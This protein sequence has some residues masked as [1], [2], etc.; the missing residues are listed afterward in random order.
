MKRITLNINEL[1]K[2]KT[3]LE[4][5]LSAWNLLLNR[6]VA[7]SCDEYWGFISD[8]QE[9]VEESLERI[10][11]ILQLVK[12]QSGVKNA[13]KKLERNELMEYIGDNYLDVLVNRD[14]SDEKLRKEII[15]ALIGDL[16]ID[17]Q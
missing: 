15:K 8:I 3:D 4:E 12:I 2:I 1:I 14:K 11:L 16:F 6:F 13:L 5:S 17:G 7:D 10:I 9:P